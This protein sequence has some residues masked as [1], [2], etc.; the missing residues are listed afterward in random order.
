MP[1]RLNAPDASTSKSSSIH[2]PSSGAT[3][4]HPHSHRDEMPPPA[5][6]A[7]CVDTAC[8]AAMARRRPT[9]RN[10]RHATFPDHGRITLRSKRTHQERQDDTPG[11]TKRQRNGV[12]P[13]HA[14][15]GVNTSSI[16]GAR[17]NS[18]RKLSRWKVNSTPV[19]PLSR[20]SAYPVHIPAIEYT[21]RLARM[22]AR[23]G[24]DCSARSIRHLRGES[25]GTH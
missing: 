8:P 9:P 1:S 15:H 5:N 18:D 10:L 4:S 3:T 17:S 12:E 20:F 21:V 16:V 25:H 7:T 2:P 24:V 6:V 23:E 11:D 19:V 22:T 13:A 14:R